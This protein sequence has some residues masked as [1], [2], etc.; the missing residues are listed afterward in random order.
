MV[1]G[2]SLISLIKSFPD[3]F[4]SFIQKKLHLTIDCND[5]HKSTKNYSY[6][7]DEFFIFSFSLPLAKRKFVDES[8]DHPKRIRRGPSSV[9]ID[10][11]N[12]VYALSSFLT[13]HLVE[14]I[15]NLRKEAVYSNRNPDYLL[16]DD[17]VRFLLEN[18]VAVE[19]REQLNAKNIPMRFKELAIQTIQKIDKIIKENLPVKVIAKKSVHEL[20]ELGV[21]ISPHELNMLMIDLIEDAAKEMESQQTKLQA[22]AAN[23][24]EIDEDSDDFSDDEEYNVDASTSK[25]TT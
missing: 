22:Q 13:K 8:R 9:L 10:I 16:F 20:I 2:K 6:N 18:R 12:N 1:V 14:S 11:C 3:F 21:I 7:L 5:D 15:L 19:L 23:A 25:K 4:L 17:V 24:H